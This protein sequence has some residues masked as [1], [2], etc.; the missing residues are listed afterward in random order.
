M[1]A[2]PP[3]IRNNFSTGSKKMKNSKKILFT[4]SVFHMFVSSTLTAS[5]NNMFDLA[6]DGEMVQIHRAYEAECQIT[7]LLI[8]AVVDPRVHPNI[9]K[10]YKSL[11][12]LSMTAKLLN[13]YFSDH[14]KKRA[15]NNESVELFNKCRNQIIGM[16]NQKDLSLEEAVIA[17]GVLPDATPEQ[18]FEAG[19][20]VSNL[21][22][23]EEQIGAIYWQSGKHQNATFK[24]VLLTANQIHQIGA[25]HGKNAVRLILEELE[26]RELSLNKAEIQ[27]AYQMIID[28]AKSSSDFLNIAKFIRDDF[29]QYKALAIQIIHNAVNKGKL[30]DDELDGALSMIQEFSPYDQST[31]HRLSKKIGSRSLAIKV[32]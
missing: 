31:I 30:N 23:D 25:T 5:S 24:H 20:A 15:I 18:L 11:P 16:Y 22:G 32:N 9:V 21:K 3:Y 29:P 17:L 8:Q 2:A 27:S 1:I 4:L 13:A 12:Q 14:I 10:D 28:I 6:I 7:D 19:K 26:E